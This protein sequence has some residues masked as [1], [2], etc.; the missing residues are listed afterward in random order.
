MI[1]VRKAAVQRP[2][3]CAGWA[4][5][6]AV[7]MLVGLL[8]L[9]AQGAARAA[10]PPAPGAGV[11]IPATPMPER[12]EGV[13]AVTLADGRVLAVGADPS[14]RY[15]PE[16]LTGQIYD[17][18]TD[19]WSLTST[20]PHAARR[21]S[22]AVLLD[23]G[24]A[25]F[26]GGREEYVSPR[27][28][29][30]AALYDPATDAWTAASPPPLD[31]ADPTFSVLLGDGRVLMVDRYGDGTATYDPRLDLWTPTASPRCSSTA[32]LA[33]L[34]DGRVLSDCGH[35]ELYDPLT[36]TWQEAPPRNGSP[37]AGG[38][39][40]LPTGGALSGDEV[41]EPATSSWR[42][43]ARPAAAAGAAVVAQST[44]GMVL[45]VDHSSYALYEA[46]TDLWLRAAHPAQ[47]I[48]TR[49]VTP[50][51]G[52][53]L[54]FLHGYQYERAQRFR[55]PAA[56]PAA[57]AEGSRAVVL[58][59]SVTPFWGVS[60][61]RSVVAT[62]RLADVDG[63]PVPGEQV[64]LYGLRDGATSW[65][66]LGTTVTD[67]DGRAVLQDVPPVRTTY[68]LRHPRGALTAAAAAPERTVEVRAALSPE[69]P[70][71]VVADPGDGYAD[72][73]WLS[74][75]HDGGS[76]ITGY[77]VVLYPRDYAYPPVPA[78][79]ARTGPDARTVRVSGLRN[80]VRYGVYVDAVNSVGRKGRAADPVVPAAGVVPPAYS[81]PSGPRDCGRL[82]G[83]EVRWSGRHV[84]CPEGVLVGPA[85]TL[86]LVGG[87]QAADVGFTGPGG[88]LLEGGAVRTEATSALA[89]ARMGR[90]GDS[91]RAW[92]G[93]RD[94]LPVPFERGP[95]VEGAA[96]V[97][98]T[99]LEI[100]GSTDGLRFGGLQHLSLQEIAVRDVTGTGVT[101]YAGG[102]DLAAVTVTRTGGHGIQLH[103]RT[104]VLPERCAMRVR[105]AR[106]DRAARGGLVIVADRLSLTG[107][108]VTSSGLGGLPA[109]AADVSLTGSVGP[110]GDVQ[111][112][113]GGGNGV[114]AVVLSGRV[115]T[116]LDWITPVEQDAGVP[117]PLG[118]VL[119]RLTM[120][121]G[122]TLRVPPGGVVKALACPG[123][124]PESSL[125]M[126]DS[127]L[128]ATDATF[129]TVAEPLDSAAPTCPSTLARHCGPGAGAWGGIDARGQSSSVALMS[130]SVR[131]AERAVRSDR[132][133]RLTAST[134]E[135]AQE[136][137][138]A[139]G[140]VEIDGSTVDGRVGLAVELPTSV[141][142]RD[143]V[144]RGGHVKVYDGF[145]N[146]G[147]P[148][149]DCTGRASVVLERNRVEGAAGPAIELTGACLPVVRDNVVRRTGG[150]GS[151][152]TSAAISLIAGDATVGPGQGISGN[153]GSANV[154]N[155]L[156]LDGAVVSDVTW[157]T[158]VAS[159][160]DVPLGYTA[161]RLTVNG[162]RR[163]V[164]PAGAVVKMASHLDLHGATLDATAGG[165]VFAALDDDSVGLPTRC[166]DWPCD[167][168]GVRSTPRNVKDPCFGDCFRGPSG[169]TLLV[170]AQVRA[171]GISVLGDPDTGLGGRVLVERSS[172]RGP[173]TVLD[174]LEARVVESQAEGIGVGRAR[175]TVVSRNTVPRASGA[176][177]NV[178]GSL[179]DRT[180]A[181]ND[182]EVHDNHVLD[183]DGPAMALTSV[184]TTLGG[185]GSAV[186]GN[187]GS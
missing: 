115:T 85:T 151:A 44:T 69:R 52:G 23:D 24:R 25:L 179:V 148:H 22:T 157:V 11:W 8:P 32:G 12:R 124:W 37:R 4:L 100:S 17:P 42:T 117:R 2:H 126:Q 161:G 16:G 104:A 77:E 94:E 177:L 93:V 137:I 63:A 34:G 57:P 109:P 129:T 103:C 33:R 86:V 145:R 138:R 142:V 1:P 49:T 169:D 78:V 158:P 105:D 160:V 106:V 119:G 30:T 56:R 133:L 48:F 183:S 111:P 20:S 31:D 121:P 84:V 7:A 65:T 171:G 141:A 38:P 60:L 50:L 46:Q 163:V 155:S 15:A 59:G 187:L 21:V 10:E 122:T 186:Q 29:Q 97:R 108:Q 153:V 123:C 143:T 116:D 3:P 43:A 74:P 182:V 67:V 166:G 70:D 178:T 72:V 184:R 71:A 53:D 75:E 130:S 35:G 82:P 45:L 96:S 62:G 172:I 19:R 90:A 5:L 87:P 101:A 40:A 139:E 156:H 140:A 51:A 66:E 95:P 41:F 147:S 180:S 61:G 88:V 128:V 175:R 118:F 68:A 89:P 173:I 55:P 120:E 28:R 91:G 113:V 83:G 36:G 136:G 149:P 159:E 176:G 47:D 146:A 112:V 152:R 162:T 134:V 58:E 102:A 125:V 9:L 6:A 114:D 164:L 110:A 76:A 27:P 80:G 81:E 127:A 150:G 170:D 13:T 64:L 144:F 135:H 165:A 54:L 18:V 79:T 131:F 154:L 107:A 98:L 132:S 14:Y 185:P 181:P 92:A 73:R 174:A 26:I 167:V 99:S 168:K 39:T